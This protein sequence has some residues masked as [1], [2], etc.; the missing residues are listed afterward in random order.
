MR[1]L[2]VLHQFLPAHV[3]GIEIYVKAL[4][5]RLLQAGNEV[6]IFC[7]DGDV[8]HQPVVQKE[9]LDG[10]NIIRVRDAGEHKKRKSQF[11]LTFRNPCLP[12]LFDQLLGEIRPDVVHVHHTLYLSGELVLAAR[13]RG[14]PVVLTVHD[15]WFLCH[16]I[17]LTDVNGRQCSGPAMGLKCPLCLAPGPGTGAGRGRALL[18]AVP[19]IYRTRYQLKIMRAV[20]RVIIPAMFIRDV[21]RKYLPGNQKIEY[22]PYGISPGRPQGQHRRPSG[23]VRFG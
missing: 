15:Y 21:I 17:I 4:S 19:L 8:I 23:K 10:L 20:D 5:E 13:K 1:I 11:L 7:A 6:F 3:G 14:I 2:Y 18:Y 9:T 22:V 16:R 12:G